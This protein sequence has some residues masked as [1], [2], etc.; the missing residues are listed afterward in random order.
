MRTTERRVD[1]DDE[2]R[3]ASDHYSSQISQFGGSSTPSQD[4]R[5]TLR[6]QGYRA[7]ES[8]RGGSEDFRPAMELT[9]E[10][11]GSRDCERNP[12]R[13]VSTLSTEADPRRTKE[14]ISN[15]RL[16]L[17][18]LARTCTEPRAR[19]EGTRTMTSPSSS[20]ERFPA[21]DRPSRPQPPHLPGTGCLGVALV[22]SRDAISG[23]RAMN[24]VTAL[25]LKAC[26]GVRLRSMTR[27]LLLGSGTGF[28]CRETTIAGFNVLE[29]TR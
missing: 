1:E 12:N 16:R 13:G 11:P 24:V 6:V 27:A 23:I 22:M 17:G 18:A 10:L 3:E 29:T 26:R 15:I 21:T 2:K 14:R 9:P 7:P 8:Q 28:G 4:R 5:A 20:Q 19:V 25:R